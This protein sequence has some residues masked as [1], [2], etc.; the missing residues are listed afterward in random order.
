[1]TYIEAYQIS[2]DEFYAKTVREILDYVLRDMTDNL[3]GFYSAEDADSEN[4]EEKFYT[5][6]NKELF[7]ILDKESYELTKKLKIPARKAFQAIYLAL[8]GKTHGPKAAWF[9][10]NQDKKFIIKRF[11]EVVD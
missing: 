10:L 2:G 1:M 9:L 6:T 8:I 11:K 3:G 4:E 5:W 7:E